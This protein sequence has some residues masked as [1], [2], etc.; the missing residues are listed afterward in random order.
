MKNKLPLVLLILILLL[1][2]FLRLW[3]IGDY[4][5]FLG[6][7]GR[8]MIVALGILHGDLT[9]LGPRSSAGE[10][11]MGPFY[12]YLV[13]PFL[14]FANYNPVGP[15]IMVALFG[16]ATVL[17]IY[18][19]GR[20]FFGQIA[21]LS[22]AALYAASPLVLAYSHTSWN[23]NILPF[24]AL[25]TIYLTYITVT[26][27][28]PWK[29]YLFIGILIGLCLQ[30]HYLSLFLA[31]IIGLYIFLSRKKITIV[32]VIKKYLILAIGTALSLSP[33]ILFEL[34]HGFLNTKGIINFIFGD[35]LS[36]TVH[37]NFFQ[38]VAEVFFRIFSRLLTNFPSPGNPIHSAE[39][40]LMIAWGIFAMILAAAAII[41]LFK[42]KNKSIILL[43]SLWLFVSV[44][45]L[46]L[47]KKEIND[48]L[49][50]FIF[51]LPFLLTGNLISYIYHRSKK[52]HLFKGLSIVLFFSI[53]AIY[54]PGI[55]FHYEPNKQR[56]QT[57]G[58]AQFVIDKSGNKPYNFAL[59]SKG[60][61]D[62][63]YRY[64]LEI[65]DQP[66]VVLDNLQND[67]KR[68]TVTDQLLIVCEDISCNPLGNPLQ[69]IAAFGR[70]NVTNVW[71]VSVVKIY[72]LE[73]YVE[74][75]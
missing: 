8:D 50:A 32:S 48:Y 59:L 18:I 72:R 74:K 62:Q 36:S 6:D 52:K 70:A 13:T 41:V 61:S 33:L 4:M 30:L 51:P 5:E 11:F 34:R 54:Y 27:N 31:I 43:L 14:W 56:D 17:L 69:D 38:T 3:K 2:A 25:L 24:F 39:P 58:I 37:T 22:A 21:G 67:P 15:A 9:L 20:K 63:A 57:K 44:L 16:I 1:A 64:Y 73:H 29:Y 65:L 53:I 7:Q 47:Y 60:N 42:H 55:Q 68:K 10:F 71:D 35:T 28:K 66:P 46:G 19:V 49:F 23:P 12:Y 45:L 75:K 40:Q 26:N